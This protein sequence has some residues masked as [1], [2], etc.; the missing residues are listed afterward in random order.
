LASM[1][2]LGHRA[3]THAHSATESTDGGRHAVAAGLTDPAT[4]AVHTPCEGGCHAVTVQGGHPPRHDHLLDICLAVLGAF[5]L[6][7]L[8]RSTRR[9]PAGFTLARSGS[10]PGAVP[11]APPRSP[12]GLTL[13][14]VSVLRT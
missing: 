11:R 3:L 12:L 10:A 13:A 2:T 5:L 14:T 9:T 1:H 7:A 4:P 6:A 8:L